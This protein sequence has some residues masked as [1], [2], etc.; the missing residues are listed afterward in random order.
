MPKCNY[1]VQNE[2]KIE[3]YIEKLCGIPNLFY[4]N[5]QVFSFHGKEHLNS[6]DLT[7]AFVFSR[8]NKTKFRDFAKIS[9]SISLVDSTH[10]LVFLD[11]DGNEYHLFC[12]QLQ[13]QWQNHG[14]RNNG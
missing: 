12:Y 9:D 2:K 5:L 4:K 11:E 6:T 10:S 13:N 14:R 3:Y 7:E 8:K 1:F